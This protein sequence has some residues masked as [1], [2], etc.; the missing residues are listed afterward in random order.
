MNAW[1]AGLFVIIILAILLL[2]QVVQALAFVIK[3][4]LPVIILLV[5]VIAVREI[6]KKKRE[7]S[8]G[9]GRKE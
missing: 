9:G 8:R 6:I 4:F 5:G 2:G 1:R 3:L 7:E